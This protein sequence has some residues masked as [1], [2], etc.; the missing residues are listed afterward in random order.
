M[1]TTGGKVGEG[2]IR[3]RTG[4][5]WTSLHVLAIKYFSRQ[6]MTQLELAR[7]MGVSRGTI[8]NIEKQALRKIRAA[9]EAR[10]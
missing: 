7:W 5:T 3:R 10:L 8:Y 2:L 1:T 4:P 9:M 6:P